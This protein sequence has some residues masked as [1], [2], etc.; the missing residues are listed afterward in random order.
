MNYTQKHLNEASQVI[1]R[2]DPVRSLSEAVDAILRN[3][4]G[5]RE[6]DSH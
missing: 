3:S 1:A 4:G 6:Q 2:I 5:G